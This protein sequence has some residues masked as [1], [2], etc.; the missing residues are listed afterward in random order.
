MDS[1]S[2]KTISV[3]KA[4]ADKQWVLVDAEGQTLGRLASKVAKLLRGKYK[5]SYTPH[6][7]CGDNVVIINAEKIN[8]TGKKWN[9]KVYVRHTGYP[10]GQRTL[11]ATE[12]FEKDPTR[13]VEKSVK[14]MLPKN[15]LGAALFR[16]L[17]V[18]VGTEHGQEAQ[19][20]TAINLNDLK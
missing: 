2:Y 17:K 20:P 6:V 14:G 16:N 3:T 19:K 12:L 18:Y 4:G 5:P 15:K 8:L 7:D 10:G 9:D 1:L 11:N 13:L